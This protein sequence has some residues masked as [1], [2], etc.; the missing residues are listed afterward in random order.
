MSDFRIEP[1][2]KSII[3]STAMRYSTEDEWLGLYK[4][5]LETTINS[6]K[7]RMFR[8]LASTQHYKLLKLYADTFNLLSLF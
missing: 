1:N 8:G 3:L 6:E 7:L 2:F 4:K 5:A